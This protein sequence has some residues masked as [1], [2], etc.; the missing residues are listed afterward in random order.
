MAEYIYAGDGGV[1]N[2]CSR[3]DETK[4]LG[5]FSIDSRTA[6]G[7]A[8]SC[9]RCRSEMT[10]EYAKKNA[11]KVKSRYKRENMTQSEYDDWRERRSDYYRLNPEYA[12]KARDRARARYRDKKEEI[13]AR[14]SS[15]S[16]REYSR[17]KMREKMLDDSFRLH[18]NVSRA[19]RSSIKDKYR[20]SWELLVGYDLPELMRHLER[21]FL[22]GMNWQNHG[23]GA[24][25]WHIDHIIPRAM[26]SYDSA[27]DPE[28]KACWA[29][30]NLR[31][32][33]SEENIRKHSKRLFLI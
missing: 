17:N 28:F 22:P 4:P 30:S 29:L 12:S 9:K 5:L 3:C 10:R 24:G 13:L 14:M 2:T 25:R 33:W 15:A 31:P 27:S 20:R 16:G 21:Q 11:D 18:S 32:L 23:K 1:F 8:S 6:T 19:I 26:H 7:F